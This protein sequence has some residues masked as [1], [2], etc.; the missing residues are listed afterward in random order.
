VINHHALDEEF[1]VPFLLSPIHNAN[2]TCNTSD[3]RY[4]VDVLDKVFG[5]AKEC[6]E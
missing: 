2:L 6:L 5:Y 3:R 4:A 1:A